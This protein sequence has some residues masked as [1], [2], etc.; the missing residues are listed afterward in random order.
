MDANDA[1]S[2]DLTLTRRR[3][4]Q[5]TAAAGLSAA[6]P[7]IAH[8][9]DRREDDRRPAWQAAILSYLAGL[10]RPDGGYAWEDQP[11][12]HLT[13]TFAAIGCHALFGT[14]PPEPDRLAGFVRTHHPAR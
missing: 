8:A 4:L 3:V 2:G 14:K 5:H 10:S 11:R 12:A 6:I 7:C 13:P 1:Q 9:R